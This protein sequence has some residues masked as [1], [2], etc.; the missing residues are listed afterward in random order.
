M[1]HLAILGGILIGARSQFA[2]DGDPGALNKMKA[3]I[4]YQEKSRVR[5]AKKEQA[6]ADRAIKRMVAAEKTQLIQDFIARGSLFLPGEGPT[7]EDEEPAGQPLKFNE[8]IGEQVIDPRTPTGFGNPFFRQIHVE[9][10]VEVRKLISENEEKAIREANLPLRPVIRSGWTLVDAR[11][12]LNSPYEA[13]AEFVMNLMSSS[14]QI[15]RRV[16]NSCHITGFKEIY[17]KRL[18]TTNVIRK[19][20]LGLLNGPF[21]HTTKNVPFD[22][23]LLHS[24]YNDAIEGIGVWNSINAAAHV[25]V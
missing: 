21:D 9:Q 23:Y 22:D 12:S 25:S 16:C 20:L 3:T 13:S 4:T 8:N 1:L 11:G 19:T 15:I 18:T 5:E 7:E 24:T 6:L 14:H 2:P 17:Y 10:A